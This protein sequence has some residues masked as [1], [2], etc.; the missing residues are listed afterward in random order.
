MRQSKRV[1]V[2]EAVRLHPNSWSSL[3]IVVLDCSENGFRAQCEAKVTGGLF[4]TVELPGIGPV[5]AVVSWQRGQQFGA[6]FVEPI[7][8]SKAGLKPLLGQ[9]LLTRLLVE[10]VAAHEAGLGQHESHLRRQILNALPMKRSV[11]RRATSA[12]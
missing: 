6:R 8:L 4:V 11:T 12:G 2:H 9:A 7:D 10:R 1:A 3:E 5:K